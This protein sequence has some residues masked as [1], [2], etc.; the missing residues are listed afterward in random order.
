MTEEEIT[1]FEKLER[2]EARLNILEVQ[3]VMI[4]NTLNPIPHTSTNI[5]PL[6]GK[7]DK[8]MP[9]KRLSPSQT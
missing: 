9:Y 7:S 5:D 2:L 4:N 1:L 6:V 8:N 3:I